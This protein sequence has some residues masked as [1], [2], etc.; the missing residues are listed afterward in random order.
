MKCE[1]TY[2]LFIL[3]GLFTLISSVP[4]R[5]EES[6]A[7]RWGISTQKKLEKPAESADS[8]SET[9]S[10]SRSPREAMGK[11]AGSIQDGSADQMPLTDAPEGDGAAPSNTVASSLPPST[12]GKTESTGTI[13]SQHENTAVVQDIVGSLREE[14]SV[15]NETKKEACDACLKNLR[16]LF[17]KTRHYSIQGASC[18]TCDQAKS[19]LNLYEKCRTRCTEKFLEENGYTDRIVRNITYLEKLGRDRCNDNDTAEVA[20]P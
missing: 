20:P 1:T 4:V 18:E 3:I 7:L 13:E 15:S 9:D 2:T 19:F 16:A 5:A 12:P 10:G 11:H 8:N 17:L 14:D 6:D